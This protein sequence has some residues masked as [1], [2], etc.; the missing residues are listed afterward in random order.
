MTAK[1]PKPTHTAPPPKAT[2]TPTPP[3]DGPTQTQAPKETPQPDISL[4]E[5]LAAL[6]KAVEQLE[7]RRNVRNGLLNKIERAQRHL[8]RERPCAAASTLR[9]FVFLTESYR[10]LHKI[11]PKDAAALIEQAKNLIEELEE[12]GAC[13]RR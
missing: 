11:S 10:R 6:H 9:A 8:E 4:S 13:R 12:L 2:R 5:E 1:P 7:T 3:K